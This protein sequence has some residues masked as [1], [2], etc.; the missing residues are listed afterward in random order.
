MAHQNRTGERFNCY[1]YEG[2]TR[3]DNGT[4]SAEREIRGY[5]Q[6]H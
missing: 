1:I 4:F 2:D 3:T 6:T 5:R